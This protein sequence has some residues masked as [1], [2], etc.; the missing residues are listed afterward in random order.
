MSLK[1]IIQKIKFLWK[2][3]GRHGVHSPFVYNFVELVL[4]EKY[5]RSKSDALPANIAATANQRKW[6]NAIADLYDCRV[7]YFGEN[8]DEGHSSAKRNLHVFSSCPAFNDTMK[9][10]DIVV[11]LNIHRN[12]VSLVQWEEMYRQ[13]RVTLSFD[14]FEMGLLFFNN[15]FLVKQHFLL[16]KD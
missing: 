6:I 13:Q 2:A 11:V 10:E 7:L 5:Q 8:P 12:E 16:R 9:E 3:K 14:L 1:T 4:N 15:E